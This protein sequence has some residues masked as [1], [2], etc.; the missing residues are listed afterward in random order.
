MKNQKTLSSY[1]LIAASLLLFAAA[2][3]TFSGASFAALSAADNDTPFIKVEDVRI[4]EG[5]DSASTMTF[6]VALVNGADSSDTIILSYSTRD[7]SAIA[8]ED[9]ET[10]SGILVLQP[11][12]PPKTIN[13]KIFGDT[14]P[15]T[16]ETFFVDFS[17]TPSILILPSFAQGVIANDDFVAILK[18]GN[19]EV[20]EGDDGITHA[21]FK[22]LLEDNKN[23]SD[24]LFIDYKTFD[25]TATANDDYIPTTGT[26]MFMPGETQK[27]V[28]VDVRGDRK[29]E[30]DEFFKLEFFGIPAVINY[31]SNI[32]TGKII[33]DDTLSLSLKSFAI[34]GGNGDS[35]LDGGECA[36]FSI[37]LKCDG[38]APAT[39][40]SA[41]LI[42]ETPDAII[43]Q[44]Q[45]GFE[46]I[47][48][49][50]TKT[51]L[52]PFSV[53]TTDTLACPDVINLM[54]EVNADGG[55]FAFPLT[56]PIGS[57][58]R[59][60]KTQV[61]ESN[62]SADIPDNSLIGA[63]SPLEVSAVESTPLKISASAHITHPKASDLTL[64]LISP[65]GTTVTLAQQ[66]GGADAQ[67]ENFGADCPADEND[68]TFSDE[69]DV[70]ISNASAPF[71]GEYAP[72]QSLSAL[73][74]NA[75]STLNG[76]WQ[77]I[78]RDS[79][80]ENAGRIECWS[81]KISQIECQTPPVLNIASKY[82]VTIPSQ[83]SHIVDPDTTV[84]V[85]L[86]NG[87]IEEGLTRRVCTGYTVEKGSGTCFG[88]GTSALVF[89]DADTT[90]TFNWKTQYLLETSA[91]PAEG[92]EILLNGETTP[93]TGWYDDGSS[94][95]IFAAAGFNYKFDVW[96][97]AVSSNI[98]PL[99]ILITSPT[100]ITA[101]FARIFSDVN[102]YDFEAT[103]DG[104]T[105]CSASGAFTP[106]AF[107]FDGSSI[108][109]SP[110][111]SNCFGFW[112]SPTDAIPA[113][114]ANTLYA[115]SFEMRSDID[116]C[117]SPTIRLRTNSA[118]FAQANLLILNS[119]STCESEPSINFSKKIQY[120]EPQNEAVGQ[121]FLIAL[122]LLNID[123][124]D[125]VSGNIY[126]SAVNVFRMSM[127]DLQNNTLEKQY[128]FD[129]SNEGWIPSGKVGSM[130]A[131]EFEYTTGSLTMTSANNI[132][133]F[134]FWNNDV[135]E[136]S[137]KP[138]KIY[139]A[140]YD[141][142]SSTELTEGSAIMRGRTFTGD[143][144]AISIIETSMLQP[145][146][147]DKKAESF[148]KIVSS[149]FVPPQTLIGTIND[150]I[151]IAFDMINISPSAPENASL[152]LN[153]MKIESFDIPLPEPTP[154]PT[155]IPTPSLSMV[156]TNSYYQGTG[157]E[158]NS[159]TFDKISNQVLV[160]NYGTD[161]SIER[162]SGTDGSYIGSTS[163]TPE[164]GQPALI[165]LSGFAIGIGE[166]QSIYLS[167]DVPSSP[168]W[169]TT[170]P[171]N[172]KNVAS[173]GNLF[174]LSR[175]LSVVGKGINTYIATTGALNNGP[176]SIWKSD[177]A[178]C[179]SFSPWATIYGA[180]LTPA[181][182]AK[183]GV[184]LSPVV[185]DM[186]PEWAIGCDVVGGIKRLR[187]FRYNASIS[188]YEW[189]S[190]ATDY[191][192]YCFD[193]DFD[194]TQTDKYK[195]I[196]AALVTT[197]NPS[198]TVGL[199]AYIL[200]FN[201][202]TKEG[203][204]TF[205]DFIPL[206]PPLANIAQRGSLD[207]DPANHKIYVTYRNPG[208]AQTVEMACIDYYRDPQ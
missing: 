189:S 33:N 62:A 97:G 161:L 179:T 7:G 98:N 58:I 49:G 68:T 168:L 192:L 80:A 157:K 190:D 39:N 204:M 141:I 10:T 15:E 54:L 180:D 112:Q 38:N 149:Y 99:E 90:L 143:C 200:V 17:S 2:G 42:S 122:D 127:P 37:S 118:N 187:L 170:S 67:G 76:T 73:L 196:I 43:T 57:E 66:A 147:S 162:Y 198:V 201:F 1:F 45:S 8:P 21:E 114:E 199:P 72:L 81:L 53:C 110:T 5:N 44:S 35:H 174:P 19:A 132:D 139:K 103:E 24:S 75:P 9:Y 6:S 119:I 129:E 56:V 22:V 126:V 106:P 87:V 148:N 88:D 113:A 105:S 131:P 41:T 121:D 207:I 74:E 107:G 50:E 82:G 136:M 32:A 206:T 181:G 40:I 128:T 12:E 203:I 120:F 111:S 30:P 108:T 47:L 142:S 65:D 175:N 70:S 205:K 177:D 14:I 100:N 158:V 208:N 25:D 159:S 171:F 123:P 85:S 71:I 27:S 79:A 64:L 166:D 55:S 137:F 59:K 86:E 83:G 191:E 124:G 34:S 130:S 184:A 172:I 46:D 144:Q 29:I 193:A 18:F 94:V 116:P 138:A 117:L 77:L 63:A 36:S 92:G 104:W 31:D 96:S 61:F 183:A 150:K 176:I 23:T 163:L 91:N 101:Q 186:P 146:S 95:A 164:T 202:D 13:V 151:G 60:I 173:A 125:A 102:R 78:A 4:T 16:D 197:G 185:G 182:A 165:T 153:D 155:P 160:S 51:N 194:L 109:I 89:V 178:G 48:W 169:K 156:W 84:S 115:I 26:L 188:N 3:A 11:N 135:S 93:A 152:S 20:K 145:P 167:D 133:T 52:T 195:P 154:T 69:A 140:T 134:G 28:Y